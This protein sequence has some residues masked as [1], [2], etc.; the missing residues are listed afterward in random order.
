MSGTTTL[1]N[2]PYASPGDP[3]DGAGN[4][5]SMMAAVDLAIRSPIIIKTND[6]S[7]VSST[8]PANDSQ[9]VLPVLANATYEMDLDLIYAA[10]AS[11]GMLKLAWSGPTGAVMGWCTYGLATTSTTS[12]GSIT[13]AHQ[14]IGDNPVLGSAAANTTNVH[15]NPRGILTTSTTAGSLQ[16]MWA[17]GASNA[18]ATIVKAGSRLKLKRVA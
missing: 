8:T 6:Q 17:Q 13:M 1:Y 14:A 11:T 10:V 7:I 3:A 9:L 15:C 18:S 2:L 5:L 4:E 12:S 16:F